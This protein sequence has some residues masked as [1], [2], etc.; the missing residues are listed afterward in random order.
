MI[1]TLRILF[2][3]GSVLL[4]TIAPLE[5]TE[6]GGKME[7]SSTAFKD[8]GTIPIQYVMVA[9][10]GKN[11]SIP[12]RWINPPEGTKSFAISIVD[13]HP[14]AKNWVHW[15]AMDIAPDVL[16][17]DEGASGK[18]MP[19]GA[20]ELKNSFGKFGYGGPQPPSGTGKHPYV[21]TVYALSVD[22]LNLVADTS[23]SVFKKALE[24]KVLG[25]ATLTGYYEQK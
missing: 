25:E 18:K 4:L 6:K 23:L 11:E 2:L 20:V 17:L 13:P 12:L 15:L 24:G 9:A 7:L 1:A 14:V 16:S 19:Q 21:V 10:G 22:K 3:V 5:G 8:E